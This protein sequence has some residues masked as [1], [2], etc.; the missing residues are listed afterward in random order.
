MKS[1]R[2]NFNLPL[3]AEWIFKEFLAKYSRLSALGDLE[4]EFRLIVEESG[5]RDARNWYWRQ[6]LKSIPSCVKHIISWRTSM[7]KNYFIVAFR[8][9]K[10]YRGYSLIN[11]T[12][13]T[14]GLACSILILLWVQDEL[15]FDRFHHKTEGLYRLVEKLQY[16]D[17]TVQYYGVTADG[18]AQWLQ[19]EFPEIVNSTRF[20]PGKRILISS[21]EKRFY[22]E[23]VAMVDPSF[24]EMF[25]FPLLNCN[26]ASVL[27]DPNSIVLT[28]R[29]A[30][31]YFGQTDPIG[32]ILTFEDGEEYQITG[33]LVNI[34]GNSH[35]KFDFLVPVVP[36]RRI[37]I[38]DSQVKLPYSYILLDD[39]AI[40]NEINLKIR[41]IF[42]KFAYTPV[43]VK[44]SLQPLIQI[45]LY[46]H[47]DW[48]LPGHGDIIFVRIFIVIAVFV[49]LIACINFMNLATSRSAKR[50]KEVGVR[51][52]L[53]G[54]RSDLVKQFYSESFLLCCIAMTIGLIIVQLFLPSF[55]NLTAKELSMNFKDNWQIFVGIMGMIF[56]ATLIAGSYPALFLSS[57]RPAQV[58]YGTVLKR[59]S[60][61]SF[62]KLMV[63]FQFAISICLI[64]SS[65][66]MSQQFNYLRKRELG[67]EKEHIIYLTVPKNLNRNLDTVKEELVRHSEN[68][69]ITVVSEL[70]LQLERATDHL[71][72]PGKIEDNNILMRI[73][74]VDYSTQD[75][76][77]FR[78]TQGRFFSLNHSTDIQHGYIVNQTAVKAMDMESPVGQEFTMWGRQGQII[79]V[80]E[81]FHF[82]SLHQRIEPLIMFLFFD[83]DNY[84]CLKLNS[85]DLTQTLRQLEDRW[86]IL[87]PDDP[88]E[89][90]FLDQM[91]ENLYRTEERF[92]AII[93]IFT[94][95][96]I[97]ISCLGLFG[98][99][100]FM[101]EQ[102]A[103][104]IS[105]RKVL[106]ASV[107]GV[108]LLLSKEFTGWVLLANIF[109]WPVAYFIMNHWLQQFAYRLKIGLIV[110]L[111]AGTFA[112]IVALIT[113]SYQSLKAALS[114]PVE[115]LRNE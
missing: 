114:N 20:F 57:F 65:F 34:P 39:K 78:M 8:H 50:S 28:S 68:I 89:Y 106:G 48:D 87:L 30:Q 5:Y 40:L 58:L 53:G 115:S 33:V 90:H 81:D 35:L 76:F 79:G 45:H 1:T 4:E 93:R 14:T 2:Q 42:P 3:I 101:V 16:A 83:W 55:N 71:N 88:F 6:V 37:G 74:R 109:A 95:L 84:L 61:V 113:V 72:W 94:F 32:K 60:A 38:S 10:R 49:L 47:F 64:V 67:F 82:Q 54:S 43:P 73:F 52:V 99:T 24:L 22:E 100:S 62:R 36:D 98:L 91:H 46:S 23:T 59:S 7:F 12:G 15:S 11:I 25:T 19:N 86:K 44:I 107:S 29:V 102:R 21:G 26:Q 13:L 18:L 80:V 111:Y 105:V 112:L 63:I 27:S 75:V 104:E 9:I 70:P 56:I 17:G 97:L 69:A 103:K 110:F 108:V 96:A 41:D 85:E 31:K 92:G 51:K 77:Q 66:I